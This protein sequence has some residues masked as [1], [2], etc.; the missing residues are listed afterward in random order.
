MKYSFFPLLSPSLS[1]S[2][3]EPL[4]SLSLFSLSLSLSLAVLTVRSLSLSLCLSLSLAVLSLLISYIAYN[5]PH[6]A[7]KDKDVRAEASNSNKHVDRHGQDRNRVFFHPYDERSARM[8]GM[9]HEEDETY[10]DQ[11]KRVPFPRKTG[12]SGRAG[13]D[14]SPDI[15]RWKSETA[16]V[17]KK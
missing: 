16:E 14:D 13:Y 10:Y 15:P 3:F 1:L 2:L 17:K 6:T 8:R 5:L 12:G 7:R 4:T 11:V 9:M